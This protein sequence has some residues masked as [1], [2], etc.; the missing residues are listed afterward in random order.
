MIDLKGIMID[1][2]IKGISLYR[3]LLLICINICIFFLVRIG[4]GGISI[5]IFVLSIML[6]YGLFFSNN[7][8]N[9][10][11]F[12]WYCIYL[13]LLLVFS[14][15]NGDMFADYFWRNFFSYH[16]LAIATFIGFESIIKTNQEL[17][18]LIIITI[19]ICLFNSSITILQYLNHP[20]GWEIGSFMGTDLDSIETYLQSHSLDTVS[21]AALCSGI[22][23]N[24]VVNGY[25]LATFFP[26]MSLFIWSDKSI[27]RILG[28]LLLLI[29]FVSIFCVQQRMAMICA[30]L[31][32]LF[33]FYRKKK[34]TSGSVFL[35]VAFLCV[36]F[37]GIFDINFDKIEFGRLST[38]TDNSSRLVLFDHM[39]SYLSSADCL[40]GGFADYCTKYIGQHNTF[41]DVI[42][43][44]G[45]IGFPLF[46][47]YF[48]KTFLSFFKEVK[49]YNPDIT[50][51]LAI[52][53]L[54]FIAYSQTHSSGIQSGITYF[55]ELVAMF[56]LS[57]KFNKYEI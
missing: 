52:S 26:I 17:N 50:S 20:L 25:F 32:L 31:F 56:E 46:I 7:K 12:K 24:G 6:L 48:I 16:F 3:A 35:F 38:Q 27:L 10:T 4:I 28:Y 42:T 33:V 9:S 55:W 51:L 21:N 36:L 53:G 44:V 11:I 47:A 40:L 54:I 41:L 19:C 8:V 13:S 2:D 37:G 14:A 29:S 43:R 49:F 45:L 39:S 30:I 57:K 34:I 18:F 5:R 1:I 23:G 15:I 22:N